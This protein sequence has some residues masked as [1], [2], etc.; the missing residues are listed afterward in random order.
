MNLAAPLSGSSS[1]Q[2]A[3]SDQLGPPSGTL[4]APGLARDA[5]PCEGQ[6][7]APRNRGRGS[8][9][10]MPYTPAASPFTRAR[11]S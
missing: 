11:L 10:R 1:Y 6:P 4:M 7:H 3:M 8:T 9:P 2:V 5:H